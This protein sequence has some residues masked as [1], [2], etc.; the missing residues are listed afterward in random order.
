MRL[1]EEARKAADAL[2]AKRQES[3]INDAQNLN[4]A[5]SRLTQRKCSAITRKALT[6]L[7][8]RDWKSG[9][10]RCSPAV[11]ASWTTKRKLSSATRSRKILN[12]HSFAALLIYP[13]SNGSGSKCDQRNFFSRNSHSIQNLAGLGQWHRKFLERKKVGWSIADYLAS[14]EKVSAN[15]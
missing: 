5:I 14:L 6:D 15:F 3:L 8:T 9:W 2:S 12:P 10:A 1:L 13:Q 11:C 4:Q 7:A